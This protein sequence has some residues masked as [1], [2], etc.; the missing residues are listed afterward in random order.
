VTTIR[1]LRER[2]WRAEPE[3]R[4]K[5]KVGAALM[6]FLAALDLTAAGVA[7]AT[8][9]FAHTDWAT[10]LFGAALIG[11]LNATSAPVVSDANTRWSA[12][13]FIH[14]AQAVVLGP[15]AAAA[16]ALAGS[17]GNI[18][19]YRPGAAR[20]A[21]NIPMHFLK[22]VAAWEVFTHVANANSSL[23]VH[24]LAGVFAG[25]TQFVVNVVLL[26]AVLRLTDPA[27]DLL[28]FVRQTAGLFLPY[29]LGYGWS[30]YGAVV[31]H[32]AAGLLGTTFIVFPVLLAQF[33]LV[34]LAR[35]VTQREKARTAHAEERD[36][37]N[38]RIAGASDAER[39]RI[40]RDLHDGVVQDLSVLASGLRTFAEQP[41]V[42]PESSGV[43][44]RAGDAAAAAT[45]ELR[46]LLRV[47]TPP[48][49][50]E[51]GLGAAILQ[52]AEPLAAEGVAVTVEVAPEL[53]FSDLSVPLLRMAQEA[54]RNTAKHAQAG[55]LLVTA[56]LL[57][58]DG[59]TAMLKIED[60]GRGFTADEVRAKRDGG[61]VGMLLIKDLAADCGGTVTVTSSPA[62]GTCIEVR[63]PNRTAS[64]RAG[65]PPAGQSPQ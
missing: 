26:A 44:K 34:G 48:D 28:L 36:K 33:F 60:D 54:V 47:L 38:R 61:H 3:P 50:A 8:I 20:T 29:N 23:M 16:N 65:A 45:E 14:L 27:T 12:A 5:V 43:A 1:T 56:S 25:L 37:L 53:E 40:A 22:D 35:S 6:V 55:S 24:V 52:L 31:L 15:V 2:L 7:V 4:P 19:R 11:S 49:L 57:D 18:I 59:S 13:G 10:L 41:S 32:N 63:V 46:T 30:V 9:S 62:K 17:A 21:F 64:P 58:G 42:D 51:I 39:R